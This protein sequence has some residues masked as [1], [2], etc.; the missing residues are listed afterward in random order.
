M[1]KVSSICG[2]WEPW[3][4]VV[5]VGGLLGAQFPQEVAERETE[6]EKEKDPS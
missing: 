1:R 5:C 4:C 2:Q 6:G 3:S